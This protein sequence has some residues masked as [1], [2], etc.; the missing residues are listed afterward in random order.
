MTIDIALPTLNYTVDTGRDELRALHAAAQLNGPIALGPYGPE[1]LAYDLVRTVLRDSRLVVPQG[2]SLAVQGIT[3]GPIWDRV[4]KLLVSID[5]AQ[6]QRLRRLVARSFT[7]RAAERMRGACVEVITE[8]IERHAGTGRCDFVADIADPYPIPIICALLGAPREDWHLFSAWAADLSKAFGCSVAE[9]E[10]A[11]LRAWAGLEGY[12]EELIAARRRSLTDDLIS[13]LIRVEDDGDR[14]S[15]E[16]LVNLAVILLNAGTDTTRNQLAAAVQT[17]AD[18]PDQWELLAA[19]PELA[20]HAV[21]ELMRHSPIVLGA[22]RITRVDVELAGVQ[23][24]AGS[25]VIANTA[26]ANRDPDVYDEPDRLD[27]MRKAAPAMLS[28]GGGMHYCLGAHLAR[29]EMTEALRVITARMADV[30]RVGP[31]PWK[32]MTGISG[33]ITLP[34]AFDA[35]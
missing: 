16:E 3:S 8:L 26:A 5:G 17:L 1:V 12:V 27:I 34:L 15:H 20:S 21:E 35:R 9:H 22:M 28:F 13:E 11:I 10:S 33:P 23:F 25:L 7:P 30:R 14:L 18:H 19:H 4:T 32:P 29:I 2:M 24:P 6:H 31:A